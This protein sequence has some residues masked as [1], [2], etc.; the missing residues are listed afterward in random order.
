M[1]ARR[2]WF[3]IGAAPADQ[4][5]MHRTDRPCEGCFR[6]TCPDACPHNT[7]PSVTCRHC[8]HTVG[9]HGS[10]GC[11]QPDWACGCTYTRSEL[12]ELT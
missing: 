3:E 8:G 12:L 2:P 11:T 5:D 1:A 10:R 4:I 7:T 6:S 9:E